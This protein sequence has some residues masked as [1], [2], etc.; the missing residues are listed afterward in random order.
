MR[1]KTG[2]ERRKAGCSFSQGDGP[3]SQAYGAS[4]PG[5]LWAPLVCEKAAF[6]LGGDHWASGP[7]RTVDIVSR[8]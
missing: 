8:D 5:I 7:L 1:Y 2:D 3:C 6:A 4:C